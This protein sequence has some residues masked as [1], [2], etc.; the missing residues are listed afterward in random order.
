MTD[1][2]E[3]FALARRWVITGKGYI[4]SAETGSYLE[5]PTKR[6]RRAFIEE[7]EE[8]EVEEDEGEFEESYRW[9]TENPHS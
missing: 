3:V 8:L 4:V 5:L 7:I 6:D 2:T 9:A 1:L